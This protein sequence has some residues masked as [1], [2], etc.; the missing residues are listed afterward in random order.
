LSGTQG[1]A[2]VVDGQ[3][4]YYSENLP[5][6]DGKTPWTGLPEPW[7]HAFD[8][9]LDAITGKEAVPLVPVRQAAYRSA[10]MEA[11]YTAARTHAWVSM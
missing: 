10:V 11:L 3:L 9:F 5:G 1:H 6:A 4:F 2:S 8:L 7:P